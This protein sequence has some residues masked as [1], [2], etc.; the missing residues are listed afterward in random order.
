MNAPPTVRLA[1]GQMLVDV[2]APEVNL[3]RAEK[4]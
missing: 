3:A 2:G 1:M 4:I